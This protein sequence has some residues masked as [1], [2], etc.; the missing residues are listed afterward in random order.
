[1]ARS[2]DEKEAR[3]AAKEAG[4]RARQQATA[5]MYAERRSMARENP[6]AEAMMLAILAGRRA[7]KSAGNLAE[8][9]IEEGEVQGE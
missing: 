6:A 9:R 4:I 1:M 3:K 2:R 5:D 8:K 7:G